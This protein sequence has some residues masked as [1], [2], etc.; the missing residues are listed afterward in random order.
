MN[1]SNDV[2]QDVRNEIIARHLKNKEH[3]DYSNG[4]SV[5]LEGI[6]SFVDTKI[7]EMEGNK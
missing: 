1:K 3:D 5:A 6:L 7:A 4:F 2:L